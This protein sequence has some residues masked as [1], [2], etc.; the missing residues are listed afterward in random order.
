MELRW[1]ASGRS[2]LKQAT[3]LWLPTFVNRTA[4]GLSMF[5]LPRIA[6]NN[7]R[8]TYCLHHRAAMGCL[9]TVHAKARD[10]PPASQRPPSCTPRRGVR[11]RSHPAPLLK[12]TPRASAK[13]ALCLPP[14]ARCSAGPPRRRRRCRCSAGGGGTRRAASGRRCGRTRRTKCP[15]ARGRGKLSGSFSSQPHSALD[16]AQRRSC[17]PS[18]GRSSNPR[19]PATT[20]WRHPPPPAA[21]RRRT[22]GSC[23]QPSARSRS[24]SGLRPGAG[25]CR[26]GR[27]WRPCR[28]AWCRRRTTRPPQGRLATPSALPTMHPA[29]EETSAVTARACGGRQSNPSGSAWNSG[30]SS[31]KS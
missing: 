21:P 5:L 19:L 13:L 26:R 22:C 4:V 23:P 11:R 10:P 17:A 25:H 29:A 2:E 15:S 8:A 16:G 30:R 6:L 24:G 20:P 14:G 7:F 9:E 12:G 27:R 31:E 1:A 18:P 3:R 28:S